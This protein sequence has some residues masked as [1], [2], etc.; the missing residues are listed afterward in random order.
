MKMEELCLNTK[1]QIFVLWYFHI[2][3]EL[4]YEDELLV[5]I[6]YR[7]FSIAIKENILKYASNIVFD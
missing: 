2:H 6:I 4:W 1:I 5:T 3:S 7:Y